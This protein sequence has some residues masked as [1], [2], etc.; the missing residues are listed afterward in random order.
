MRNDPLLDAARARLAALPLAPA[1]RQSLRL[2]FIPLTDC[3]SLIVASAAGLF[4][5]AGLDVVL[6]RQPSWAV[7]RDRLLL[8]ELDA[9]HALYGLAFDMH[10]GISARPHPMAILMGLNRNG[11]GIVLSRRLWSDGVTDLTTL[12]T[13]VESGR[14]PLTFAH[15]FP[16]GT[17]AFWLAYWLAAGG[18][19]PR[20][21]VTLV[22]VPPAQMPDA[23][24]RGVIDGYCVG[25]PWCDPKGLH[26]PSGFRVTSTAEIWRNHPEK[27]LLSSQRLAD[28]A[29]RT[30]QRLIAALLE[31]ARWIDQGPQRA[32]VGQ[33][34]ERPEFVGAPVGWDER[35][36]EAP[37]PS[38]RLVF[39]GIDAVNAPHPADGMWFMLQQRRWGLLS[40]PVDYRRIATEVGRL[41]LYDATL[42]LLGM[43]RGDYDPRALLFDGVL[44]D[45]AAAASYLASFPIGERDPR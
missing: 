40:A 22:T 20:S 35:D 5:A 34:L 9:A 37:V 31:A 16:T 32:S 25:E 27:I 39:Y 18:I 38:S 8:G 28:A 4:A 23:M 30:C 14:R 1:E 13:F 3:A 33:L 10:L 42:A 44:W 6:T 21:Q 12:R 36:P 43:R 11:Q 7:L 2:G 17:H 26:H 19:D 24:A 29:P 15:T 41:A 45:P